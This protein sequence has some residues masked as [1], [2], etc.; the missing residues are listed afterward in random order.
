MTTFKFGS[1]ART[2]KRDTFVGLLSVAKGHKAALFA[3]DGSYTGFV[4][5]LSSSTYLQA[6]LVQSILSGWPNSSIIISQKFPPP[7]DVSAVVL[8]GNV[9]D[10]Y[11][12]N[13][14]FSLG[15]V[16]TFL[17]LRISSNHTVHPGT[18]PGSINCKLT[19][20]GQTIEIDNADLYDVNGDQTFW[21][22]AVQFDKSFDVCGSQ[23]FLF[24]FT[25]GDPCSVGTW[26]DF[27]AT[28]GSIM[29]GFGC[30]GCPDEEVRSHL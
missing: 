29:Y 17:D 19:W 6:S 27:Q 28:F 2:L 8:S 5:T 3:V 23:P 16:Q 18:P 12:F 13:Q 11:V 25:S 26:D 15:G 24:E 9:T 14:P 30:R 21:Q 7:P 1:F 10:T 20:G 4:P 22:A